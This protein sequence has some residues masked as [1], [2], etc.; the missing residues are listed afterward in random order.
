M[1]LQIDWFLLIKLE[2]VN[3]CV[4]F[5]LIDEE[6]KVSIALLAA[7]CIVCVNVVT[8]YGRNALHYIVM[9]FTTL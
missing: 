3:I 6:M 1:S 9:N 8:I 4:R 7:V 5:K 2:Y